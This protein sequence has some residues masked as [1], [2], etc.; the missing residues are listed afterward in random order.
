MDNQDMMK[1]T[2]VWKL[3]VKLCV[4]TVIMTLVM[5]LYNMTDIFF[6]G[7]TKNSSMVSALSVCMPVFMIVQAFGSL[8]GGGGSTAIAIALGRG[9]D[10]KIRKFSSFCCYASII[11]G[12]C[13]AV[14]G[15]VFTSQIVKLLGSADTY[16]SYAS[17][18]LR[19]ICAGSP[20]MIFS[21]SFVN[22]MRADGSAK[23][24]MVANLSGTITNIILDPVFILALGMGAAG[25]AIATV[26]GNAV[27]LVLAIRHISKHAKAMSLNIKNF[28]LKKEISLKTLSL[29]LPTA[30]GTLLVSVAYTVMNNLLVV[31]DENATGAFGVCR[32]IMLMSTMIQMGISMGMQPA[33]SFNYGDKNMRRVKEITLKTGLL[34]VIFGICV[35]AVCISARS[36][37][38]KLFLS[39][40]NVLNYTNVMLVGC[41]C[42]AP[43]YGI[44]EQSYAFLQAIDRAVYGTIVTLLRQGIVLIP[45]MLLLNKIGGFNAL[46]FS[47][48]V[49]DVIAAAVG[50]LLSVYWY[51]KTCAKISNSSVK[52]L[53]DS[54]S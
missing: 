39:D 15:N 17:S 13:I 9:Q 12:L 31:I 38:L 43:I 35:A 30:A 1:N 47:F 28:T 10:E 46:I 4:P 44:Y 5:A 18:Y 36:A 6:V 20:I 22:I 52:N 48:A 34:T 19:I 3:I 41:L 40:E 33:I 37:V 45:V 32:T 42:T 51:R 24:S 7:L 14:I 25:A 29:G 21:Y 49:T 50:L 11:I 2:P 26:I 27:S 16:A 23:E 8:I 54:V 53:N